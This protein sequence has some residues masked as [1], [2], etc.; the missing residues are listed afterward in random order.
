MLKILGLV[1]LALIASIGIFAETSTPYLTEPSLSPDRKE[2]AFVSG[3]DI[4]SV[5]SEGGAARLLVSHA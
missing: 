3:G 1:S 5:P 2:I 4:W